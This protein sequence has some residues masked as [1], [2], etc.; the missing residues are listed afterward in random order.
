MRVGLQCA[1]SAPD[2][3]PG[4][5]DLLSLIDDRRSDAA[6]Y[7][8]EMGHFRWCAHNLLAAST[9]LRDPVWLLTGSATRTDQALGLFASGDGIGQPITMPVKRGMRFTFSGQIK[10]TPGETVTLTLNPAICTPASHQVTFSADWFFFA[11]SVL[12]ES[13]GTFLLPSITQQPTDTAGSVFLTRLQVNYGL[14]QAY[15]ENRTDMPIFHRR[16]DAYLPAAAGPEIYGPGMMWE[17]Q[18]TNFVVNSANILG[19]TPGVLG[20]GGSLPAHWDGSIPGTLGQAEVTGSG[21]EFGLPYVDV[22]FNLQNQTSTTKDGALYFN[23][24]SNLVDAADGQTWTASVFYRKLAGGD[25]LNI[26]H[27][28][29][30]IFAANSNGGY[31][32]IYGNNLPDEPAPVFSRAVR[33]AT[34]T[35][36]P[37]TAKI[38]MALRFVLD[39]G[40]AADVTLRLYAPQLEKLSFPTSP[41][42]TYGAA[43]TRDADIASEIM[44]TNSPETGALLVQWVME[45]DGLN[46][47]I[48]PRLLIES[49][50]N[51]V[52]HGLQI[53]AASPSAATLPVFRLTNNFTPVELTPAA[54]QPNMVTRAAYCWHAGGSNAAVNQVSVTQNITGYADTHT[55]WRIGRDFCGLILSAERRSGALDPEE[56]SI[57]TS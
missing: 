40:D 53:E 56:L 20:S 34:L 15:V 57:L 4:I 26:N 14:S 52:G 42:P 12:V 37:N 31:A 39:P 43:V 7:R 28:R 22:R 29:I 1:L 25:F 30:E 16:R 55:G 13:D 46:D 51:N 36:G 23:N 54:Q 35:S 2:S 41:I 38:T 45:T 5:C 21:E 3:R 50:G 48:G 27:W 8:D 18:S 33:T 10:G 17:P 19:A 11:Y 49:T 24:W 44:E 32:G 6:M 9:D 47:N